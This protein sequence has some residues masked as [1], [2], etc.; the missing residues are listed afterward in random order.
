MG[1]HQKKKQCR[2]ILVAE[3]Q[4]V[5]MKKCLA[6]VLGLLGLLSVGTGLA[7]QSEEAVTRVP[8]GE[9]VL[10]GV[11]ADLSNITPSSGLDILQAVTLAVMRINEREG[12]IEGFQ[13]DLM[14]E[15][16][17]CTQEGAIPVAQK[18]ASE[19][20]LI[21][22]VGHLCSGASIPAS[23]VYE[24]ARVVMVSPASTA[25]AFT[26]RGLSVVNRTI[27]NDNVQGVV[28]A[29]YIRNILEVENIVI[30]H[31]RTP[32]GLGLA[33]TVQATFTKSLGGRVLLFE[34]IDRTRF[35]Y[36]EVLARIARLKPELI[37]FGGYNSEGGF[38][39]EQIRRTAGLEAVPFFGADGLYVQDYLDFSGDFAEGSYATFPLPQGDP[40]AYAAFLTLYEREFGVS[41]ET[42][43]PYHAHAYDAA[44]LIL[45]AAQRIARVDANGTLVIDREALIAAVRAT[46]RHRGLSGMLTCNE[47]GDCAR[48]FIQVYQVQ[49][50]AW[51]ALNV[52]EALQVS[53]A[54]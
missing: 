3:K 42:L 37:Y 51:K 8:A 21:G 28:A 39:I 47:R 20:N 19:P 36:G 4:G 50:G 38:L 30:L 7:R 33:E 1:Y 22:V 31:N 29:R 15:D 54:G 25:D 14:V 46:K 13:V 45:R 16:D 48:A 24:A 10:L 49:D 32:Y 26:N 23:E 52:P 34:G 17:L 5:A 2:K 27:V 6:G 12:G 43:S 18:L 9:P 40:G 41:P 11:A 35:E 44:M 53:D